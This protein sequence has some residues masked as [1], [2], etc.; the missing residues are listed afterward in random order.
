MLLSRLKGITSSYEYIESYGVLA[1]SLWN[2]C[3]NWIS[4]LGKCVVIKVDCIKYACNVVISVKALT[5]LLLTLKLC[6][7]D[8]QWSTVNSYITVILYTQQLLTIILNAKFLLL[9]GIHSV[10]L[11]ASQ[12]KKVQVVQ[13]SY[14]RLYIIRVLFCVT[15]LKKTEINSIKELSLSCNKQMSFIFNKTHSILG[16]PVNCIKSCHWQ[17]LW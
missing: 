14:V 2:E 9:S 1:G 8:Y 15:K 12:L 10:T 6:Y 11:L 17:K 3:C 4:V 7:Y 5:K 13:I 16:N